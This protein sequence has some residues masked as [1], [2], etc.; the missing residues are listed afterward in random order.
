[1]T[2]PEFRYPYV[3]AGRSLHSSSSDNGGGKSPQVGSPDS[4]SASQKSAGS[5]FLTESIYHNVRNIFNQNLLSQL[6]FCIDR[7]SLNHCSASLVTLT[8]RTCAYAFFFCPGVADVLVRLWKTSPDGLRRVVT[9][10][11]PSFSM[12]ARAQ[13][14]EEVA[15]YFPPALRSLSFTS[16]V[17]LVRSLRERATPPIAAARI[18][19]YGS[20]ITKWNGRETDL[21]FVF[22]KHFHLLLAD[23][24]P[25]ASMPKSKLIYI[26]G[27]LIIQTQILRL[28]D[29]TLS[30]SSGELPESLSFTTKQQ[31]TPNF[32]D[33]IAGGADTTTAA[34]LGTANSLRAMSENRLLLLLRDVIADHQIGYE[35][36]LHFVEAMSDLLKAVTRKTSLFDHNACFVLMDFVQ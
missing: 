26:P 34:P 8:A 9:L 24:A 14:S 17:A 15:S 7:M 28:L 23:F 29:D 16:H 12:K 6:G 13:T 27:L 19:W 22:I 1:M 5:D 36:R 2:R 20:W 10:H 30:R 21:L 33:I 3:P 4:G 25:T 11:D 31:R 18:N 32:D 35:V